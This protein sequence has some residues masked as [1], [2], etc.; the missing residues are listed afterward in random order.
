MLL[1]LLLFFNYTNCLGLSNFVLTKMKVKDKE[2]Q[3]G[4]RPIRLLRCDQGLDI[5]WVPRLQEYRLW[6]QKCEVDVKL[7]FSIS[8]LQ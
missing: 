4:E 3:G 5:Q 8:T 2:L 7:G 1:L 6:R